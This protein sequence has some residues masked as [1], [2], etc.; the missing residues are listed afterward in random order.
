VLI[1]PVVS[2]PV[3]PTSV[4]LPLTAPVLPPLL[5]PGSLVT[6]PPLLLPPSV[7]PLASVVLVTAPVVGTVAVL[8]D[9]AS[10]VVS[11]PLSVAVAVVVAV[12][13]ARSPSSEQAVARASTLAARDKGFEVMPP[14]APSGARR[15]RADHPVPAPARVSAGGA[16]R[17]PARTRASPMHPWSSAPRS[18]RRDHCGAFTEA[19]SLRRD[20]CGLMTASFMPPG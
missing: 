4:V 20:H 18:L 15:A 16:A 14:C 12:T 19:R 9:E 17:G 8:E 1:T 5:L 10:L 7:T 2:I 11:T 3:V 13:L 6:V